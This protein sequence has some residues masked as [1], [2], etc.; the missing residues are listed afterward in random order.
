MNLDATLISVSLV[1]TGVATCVLLGNPQMDKR[2][3][4]TDMGAAKTFS[5]Q[6]SVMQGDE[7]AYQKLEQLESE[8]AALKE[9][10]NSLT[11][12]LAEA[13]QKHLHI[14]PESARVEQGVV[15]YTVSD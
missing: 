11:E 7:G 10:M 9:K 14:K 1:A 5:P 13:N 4:L 3:P 8:V 15:G 12:Q 2:N 6:T